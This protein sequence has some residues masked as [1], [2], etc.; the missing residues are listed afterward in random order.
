M[1]G[2]PQGLKFLLQDL[3]LRFFKRVRLG[4]LQ[5]DFNIIFKFDTYFS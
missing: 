5:K 2:G 1:G 3:E 4:Y